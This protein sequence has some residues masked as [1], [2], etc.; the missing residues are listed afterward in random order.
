MLHVTFCPQIQQEKSL[1]CSQNLNRLD[2][3]A[4]FFGIFYSQW[5]YQLV[6]ISRILKFLTWHGLDEFGWN[7]P[8]MSFPVQVFI[9]NITYSSIQ[10]FCLGLVAV[11]WFEL[12]V[13]NS[14]FQKQFG[15]L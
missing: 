6:N 13:Y 10:M 15:S 9:K 11:T 7:D 12:S 14:Q 1:K 3:A 5:D 8:Y 4:K 2:Y